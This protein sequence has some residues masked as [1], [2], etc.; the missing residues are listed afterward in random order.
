MP[1]LSD[2]VDQAIRSGQSL[3]ELG[4]PPEAL[5]PA[6]RYMKLRQLELQASDPNL[7]ATSAAGA[8]ART[9][10]ERAE[11]EFSDRDYLAYQLQ[12]AGIKPAPQMG[13]ETGRVLARYE[14]SRDGFRNLQ[15][16][17]VIPE[18]ASLRAIET[19]QGEKVF[20][21][22]LP[23]DPT[24]YRLTPDSLLESPTAAL[25]ELVA[26]PLELAGGV[27]GAVV[28]GPGPR[29]VKEAVYTGLGRLSDELLERQLGDTKES[30]PSMLVESGEAAAWAAG[31]GMAFDAAKLG[32]N[33][34]GKPGAPTELEGLKEA[35]KNVSQTG[36]MEPYQP[37][38]AD[39]EDATPQIKRIIAMRNKLYGSGEK[40]KVKGLQGSQRALEALLMDAAEKGNLPVTAEGTLDW[41]NLVTT[42]D[43]DK[44]FTVLAGM[45][46]ALVDETKQKLTQKSGIEA[47]KDILT[48]AARYTAAVR[49]YTDA[50]EATTGKLYNE[51][52]ELA[53]QAAANGKPIEFN[54]E[55]MK[56]YLKDVEN[57]PI[58]DEETGAQR[59]WAVSD[60]NSDLRVVLANFK[61]LADNQSWRNEFTEVKPSPG[62][63]VYGAKVKS[64]TERRYRKASEVLE[65]LKTIRSQLG[66][67]IT[68]D[69]GTGNYDL[70]GQVAA[71]LYGALSEAIKNP[72]NGTEAFNKAWKAAN[73][74][75]KDH[76]SVMSYL[77]AGKLL[78]TAEI[79][80]PEVIT[81]E[82]YSRIASDTGSPVTLLGT[83]N[84]VLP[85][86]QFAEI[87][88]GYV[89]TLLAD[90]EKLVNRN[91]SEAERT[92]LS[93]ETRKVLRMHGVRMKGIGKNDLSK[94]LMDQVEKQQMVRQLV[95]K[96]APGNL[97]RTLDAAG[98]PRELAQATLFADV[99]ARVTKEE[100]NRLFVQPSAF[101]SFIRGLKT[102]KKSDIWKILSPQQRKLLKDVDTLTSFIRR[103]EGIAIG[104][105]S[106]EILSKKAKWFRPVSKGIG[107]AQSAWYGTL[108]WLASNPAIVGIVDRAGGVSKFNTNKYAR[109]VAI[110]TALASKNL[111]ESPEVTPQEKQ[112]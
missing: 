17:G 52:F 78:D 5:G 59:N 103:G 94:A 56:A 36:G 26:Q 12:G 57:T 68:R 86:E 32:K 1:Q 24:F 25:G 18:E 37:T 30:V 39:F 92:L 89:D 45:R 3:E 101:N 6:Q 96:S 71:K 2:L 14:N 83:L 64:V 19:P 20:G 90:P 106:N 88:N 43:D 11:K 112:Q 93:E 55:K 85:K 41:D 50:M 95:T 76:M 47:G 35:A 87:K 84:R 66:A 10:L 105:E 38:L 21:Y 53:D 46:D 99:L 69:P 54:L 65:S 73:S 27:V 40:N 7:D 63:S 48:R 80:G 44:L 62:M 33:L 16:E 81:R 28:G 70:S 100:N 97:R 77:D 98:V 42:V 58:I 51:A 60:L 110:G 102:D 79:E 22:Q 34:I 15:K 111:L 23:D 108:G 74:A 49:D 29:L 75:H 91:W 82:L 13:F 72:V 4:L 107:H 9:N 31:T 104:L 109:A 8:E 61:R 67:M